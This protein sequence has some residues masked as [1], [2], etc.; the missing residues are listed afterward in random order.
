MKRVKA[1]I[2]ALSALSMWVPV[3]SIHAGQ[4]GKGPLKV[5]ILAGQSNM[6]GHG[7]IKGRPGQK[8][9]LETLAKDTASAARYKHLVDKDG[10]WVVRGDVWISY[11]NTKAK[12]AIGNSAAR[13]SIGPE[14]AFGW[15][16]GDYLDE[17]VLL[18][19]FGPGGT[20]L[21][22]PWRPPS[23]GG[24]V[25]DEYEK[26]IAGVKRQLEHL[27]ADFPD[28]DGKGY[29]IVGFGWHQGWND[30]CSANLVAEY[31]KNMANFIR[32]VRKDLGVPKMP[33]VI[34][35]SGFGG[36]GQRIDRRLGIMKA[37]AAMEQY[38]EFKGNVKYVETRGFF[39]D[40][41][42]SPRPI[43]YHWCC[44]A[45]SYYLIGEAMGKAMV[46]LLGGPKAPANPTGPSEEK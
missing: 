44:N 31:E 30:G 24:T 4:V 5:F 1:G 17:Q 3:L 26:M 2:V 7:V 29:E 25:G 16:V 35:G 10:K 6:E 22:G 46:E 32:D 23:S 19:K 37:Q 42:V 27:K 9:T 39:R 40:G 11:Y 21:A 41:D 36:W 8:G 15:A 14:L 12:L 18:I 34:A 45:E 20:S 33:F 28:H 13:N 43:R 38:D